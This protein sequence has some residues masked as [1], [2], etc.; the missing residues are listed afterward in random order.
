MKKII[1]RI[2]HISF[3]KLIETVVVQ[4]DNLQTSTKT[5]DL[6][7]LLNEAKATI[8][9]LQDKTQSLK[10]EI[11]MLRQQNHDYSKRIEQLLDCNNKSVSVSND[12]RPPPI[13]LEPIVIVKEKQD[14]KDTKCSQSVNAKTEQYD[15]VANINY[16]KDYS[17]QST[18]SSR[19]QSQLEN[20]FV[21]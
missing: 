10:N 9:Q 8:L 20:T 4:G 18:S 14:E 12:V 1:H 19:S 17:E 3:S 21:G 11:E 6:T 7:D 5:A 2:L 16:E 13:P 15:V